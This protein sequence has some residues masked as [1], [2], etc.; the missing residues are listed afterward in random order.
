[1]LKSPL[2]LNFK[3]IFLWHWI[4]T[5]E[6]HHC[7]SCLVKGSKDWQLICCKLG[8][9]VGQKSAFSRETVLVPGLESSG[10]GMCLFCAIILYCLA[11]MIIKNDVAKHV[12]HPAIQILFEPLLLISLALGL[13]VIWKLVF[14]EHVS[15][16]IFRAKLDVFS[17]VD[18]HAAKLDK[19]V[20]WFYCFISSS[21]LS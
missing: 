12:L 13:N 3:L 1:M 20:L 17:T 16:L 21:F 11:Y 15:M 8:F 9:F 14:A 19:G 2:L 5:W 6:L 18:F 10:S 7:L 4:T